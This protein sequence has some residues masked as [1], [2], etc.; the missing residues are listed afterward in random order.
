[1]SKVWETISVGIAI[2]NDCRIFPNSFTGE[3]LI[4]DNHLKKN[5]LYNLFLLILYSK[6]MAFLKNL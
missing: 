3:I 1:M 6:I 5:N 2:H 4:S